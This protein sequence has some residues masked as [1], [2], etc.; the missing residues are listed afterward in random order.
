VKNLFLSIGLYIIALNNCSATGEEYLSGFYINLSGDTINGYFHA[1]D[2]H[3]NNRFTFKNHPGEMEAR[4]LSFDSCKHISVNSEMYTSWYGKRG[5]C[6]ISQPD[7]YLSNIDS[8]RT[9]WIPLKL[10]Y[11]GKV[12]SL[13]KYHDESDHFFVEKSGKIEELLIA[14]RY[15]TDW[16]KVQQRLTHKTYFIYYFFRTQI[17]NMVGESISNRQLHQAEIAQYDATSL[18]SLF[19]LLD[20]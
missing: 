8:F 1:R 7:L 6:Y 19:R 11:K 16:E 14:Y 18:T 5:M 12:L 15:L 17:I 4:V 2:L 10:L 3:V 20:K 9:E 13:Y